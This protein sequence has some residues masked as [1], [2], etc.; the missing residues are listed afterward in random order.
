VFIY[1]FR[2]F[3]LSFLLETMKAG[4]LGKNHLPL[5]TIV[6]LKL[7]F[8]LFS[9]TFRFYILSYFLFSSNFLHHFFICLFCSSFHSLFFFLPVLE[10]FRH[11]VPPVGWRESRNIGCNVGFLFNPTA[12][13]RQVIN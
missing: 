12:A 6:M 7:F 3:D 2:S 1:F 9:P 11:F 5:F 13:Y 8:I 10:P 4:Y